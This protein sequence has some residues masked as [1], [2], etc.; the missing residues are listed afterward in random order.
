VTK[1]TVEECPALDAALLAREGSLR[2]GNLTII[3]WGRSG[4]LAGMIG[5]VADGNGGL[6]VSYTTSSESTGAKAEDHYRLVTVQVPSAVGLHWFFECPVCHGRARKL[7]LPPADPAPSF[8]CRTCHSLAYLSQQRRWAS[9]RRWLDRLENLDR[10]VERIDALLSRPQLGPGRPS[11]R[12]LRERERAVRAQ[13]AAE[14]AQMEKRAPG[15]PKEKRPYTR[16]LGSFLSPWRPTGQAWCPRC[17]DRRRMLRGRLVSMANS[18]PAVQGRCSTC[19]SKMLRIVSRAAALA[20]AGNTK[21][22][23]PASTVVALAG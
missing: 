8:A 9:D 11:K 1:L 20:M 13:R 6:L 4:Q 15:R 19:Q 18:R 23:H 17:R 22:H 12:E 14:A 5:A 16:H 3:S 21:K 2:V 7:Y 10:E